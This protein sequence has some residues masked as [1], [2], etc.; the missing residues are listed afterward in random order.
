VIEALALQKRARELRVYSQITTANLLPH[1]G[2]YVFPHILDVVSVHQL[3]GERYFEVDVT[4]GS[5]HQV[6][7][8]ICSLPYGYRGQPVVVR[9]LELWMAELVARLRRYTS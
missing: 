2:G 9:T 5:G 7:S 3:N 6:V 8:D 1:G 4:T